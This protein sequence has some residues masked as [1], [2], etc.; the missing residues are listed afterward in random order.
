MREGAFA[1]PD[2]SLFED[3]A[4]A[5]EETRARPPGSPFAA[6]GSRPDQTRA[7]PPWP[8][9]HPPGDGSTHEPRSTFGN[10]SPQGG[11]EGGL[12]PDIR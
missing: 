1:A 9:H 5:I 8:S 4:W 3:A 6:A 12:T 2:W 10:L 11:E 7:D